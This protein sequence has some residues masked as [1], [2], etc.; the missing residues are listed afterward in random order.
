LGPGERLVLVGNKDDFE[1]SGMIAG[2]FTGDLDNGGER[3]AL[4]A[5]DGALIDELTFDDEFPWPSAADGAGYSLVKSIGGEWRRSGKVGGSPGSHDAV[6]FDGVAGNDTDS[7]GLDDLLE[8][9]LGANP[10]ESGSGPEAIRLEV[11]DANLVL[12]VTRRVGADSL[13][14]L[15]EQSSD[16]E[17]WKVSD[18]IF[19]VEE[20]I[21]DERRDEILL[22]VDK[23]PEVKFFRLKIETR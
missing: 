4:F 5:R 15:V 2:E 17:S 19:V 16:L 10:R 18:S 14:M 13:Q 8:F 7:D 9:Y 21:L 3:I 12:R 11:H 6:E 22:R 23:T 20:G 1:E